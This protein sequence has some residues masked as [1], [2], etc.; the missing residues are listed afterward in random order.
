MALLMANGSVR[1][2]SSPESPDVLAVDDSD[3]PPPAMVVSDLIYPGSRGKRGQSSHQSFSDTPQIK[4]PK[5]SAAVE[6]IDDSEDELNGESN[7]RRSTDFSKVVSRS[8]R[9]E[10][11]GDISRTRFQTTSSSGISKPS[12]SRWRIKRAVGGSHWYEHKG[13][14]QGAI[15]LD[16]SNFKEIHPTTADGNKSG[17]SWLRFDAYKVKQI[18]HNLSNSPHIILSQP[19]SAS[20]DVELPPKLYLEFAENMA[21]EPLITHQDMT[22]KC[23]E[24]EVYV[25]R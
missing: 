22:E 7:Q 21:L 17:Q 23:K 12:L 2:G 10:S 25:I 11:R 9:V 20:A 4:R 5:T 19:S 15:S 8:S 14:D 24:M 16:I 1:S 3:D 18:Q 6:T 13:N